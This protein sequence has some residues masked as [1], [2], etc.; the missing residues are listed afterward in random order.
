MTRPVI[1]PTTVVPP[2]RTGD[3]AVAAWLRVAGLAIGVVTSAVCG[4]TS[5]TVTTARSG[6][7]GGDAGANTV[8]GAGAAALAGNDAGATATGTGDA[9]ATS[10]TGGAC[11]KPP[12]VAVSERPTGVGCYVGKNGSWL[13]VPCNCELPLDN[14]THSALQVRLTL[15]VSSANVTPVLD[16]SPDIEATFDDPDESWYNAWTAQ[17]AGGSLFNVTKDGGATTV[18]LGA[19]SVELAPVSLPACESRM[20]LAKVAGTFS[21]QLSLKADLSD[22]SGAVLATTDGSCAN[23]L[24]L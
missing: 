18:R 22:V 14:T 5:A 17:A 20:G 9:G 13:R 19:S 7:T 11:G 2:F 15:S 6:A 4:C 16:G 23:P 10:A 8:T 1:A 3:R 21:A 12:N 24:P